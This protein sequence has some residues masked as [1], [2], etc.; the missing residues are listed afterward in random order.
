MVLCAASASMMAFNISLARSGEFENCSLL[1]LLA[2]CANTSDSSNLPLM[3]LF[4]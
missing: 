4:T 3:T 2:C 1:L